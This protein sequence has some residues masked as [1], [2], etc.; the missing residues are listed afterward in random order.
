MGDLKRELPSVRVNLRFP[1]STRRRSS[2]RS[3]STDRRST[4]HSL[5]ALGSLICPSNLGLRRRR[6]QEVLAE[7]CASLLEE[8]SQHPRSEDFEFLQVGE[9][10]SIGSLRAV[11]CRPRGAR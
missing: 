3:C 6:T 8:L 2:C 11:I 7:M 9:E 4:T 1:L 5:V 10:G